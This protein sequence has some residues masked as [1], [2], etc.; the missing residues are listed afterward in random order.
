MFEYAPELKKEWDYEKN[1][2]DPNSVSF[3][4]CVHVYWKCENKHSYNMTIYKKAI[5][6]NQCPYCT[7]KKFKKGFND[8][9]LILPN[10]VDQYWDYDRNKDSIMPNEIF[11]SSK[12]FAFFKGSKEKKKIVTMVQN[13]TKQ[14]KRKG[15]NIR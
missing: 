12:K 10:F 15:L 1:Q 2:I 8:L 14:L 13:Y 4:S 9:Q 3:N 5:S 11:K 6:K 7:H